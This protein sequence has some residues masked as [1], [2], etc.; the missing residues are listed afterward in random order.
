MIVKLQDIPMIATHLSS[1]KILSFDCE[2][3]G[4]YPWQ[5]DRM[6]S[7]IIYD[8]EEAFYF[9]FEKHKDIPDPSF[10]LPRK[11]KNQLRPIFA[12]PDIL[13][14]AHNAKFDVN[15]L[16]VDHIEVQGT[17]HC[18]EVHARLIDNTKMNYSLGVL[19]A[20]IGFK[21]DEQVEAFIKKHDLYTMNEITGDKSPCFY[22]VPFQLIS[23]YAMQD[24]RITFELG[25]HQLSKLSAMS[26]SVSAPRANIQNVIENER[27]MTKIFSEMEKVGITVNK[28][29]SEAALAFESN[30]AETIKSDWMKM[31]GEA[32]TDSPKALSRAFDKVGEIYPTTEKGNPS[33]TA[34]VLELMKSPLATMLKDYRDASKRATTYF[35]NFLFFS[36][37]DDGALHANI[38][39]AGTAT[40]RLSYS[41]PNLQNLS[42]GA[43]KGTGTPYPIRKAFVPRK[44]FCFVMIDFDQMEYRLMLDYAGEKGL[45]D[46]VNSGLDVHQATAQM[47]STESRS[48]SRDE[49]KTINFMLLYGGG[50]A[51]LAMA[52]FPTKLP[53]KELKLLQMS[54]FYPSKMTQADR[55]ALKELPAPAVENDAPLLRKA[56]GLKSLYF[57]KLPKV[58]QF[59]AKVKE[60][61]IREKRIINWAG[62]IY[63][64]NEK[65]SHKAPN[66]LIQGSCAD[67]VKIG[68][69]RLYE[70]LKGK[71][72]QM[73]IQVH[74]EIV[75]EV[76]KDELHIVPELQRILSTVY[77]AKSLALTCG[78]DHSWV[79]WADKV[80]G[81][82][83]A[84]G[85]PNV[86]PSL[87]MP[88][89]RG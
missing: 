12:N 25:M 72:S 32:L 50:I 44:D 53:E 75:F 68:M 34:E 39:Q 24:A 83:K 46:L 22:K 59:V 56:H 35:K 31:T 52:L 81:L 23:S 36:K 74:D 70:F 79:S 3:T 2:T 64:F 4:L 40:G 69:R 43:E 78:V 28:E 87:F 45:I 11:I 14:F 77:P 29:F 9:N 15:M 73:L 86:D 80:E 67:I 89:V 20:E 17:I 30:R 13:W 42:K 49:A 65:S 33:F 1:K 16:K 63:Q 5:G 18:T 71:K 21:K 66:Y 48:V 88:E 10:I 41:E 61:A 27:A 60:V 37:G 58:Q 54:L 82:P 6:F 57:E 19:A 38:R 8:G 26:K 7:L 84:E 55:E 47:M 85:G 76:H 51:K 62:R